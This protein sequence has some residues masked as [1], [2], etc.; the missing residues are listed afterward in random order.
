LTAEACAAANTAGKGLLEL[1]ATAVNFDADTCAVTK[2]SA[3]KW[4]A[5]SV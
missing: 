1:S 5:G 2:V 4:A 3:R